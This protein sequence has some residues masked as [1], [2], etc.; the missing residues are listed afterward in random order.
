MPPCY[1]RLDRKELD[2][3]RWWG[4]T[5]KETQ[6]QAD[7]CFSPACVAWAR[8]GRA[9]LRSS[10]LPSTTM[11]V[12]DGPDSSHATQ[13]GPPTSRPSITVTEALGNYPFCLSTCGSFLCGS[14]GA[15]GRRRWSRCSDLCQWVIKPPLRE[16]GDPIHHGNNETKMN[17]SILT[18]LNNGRRLTSLPA[19]SSQR[20]SS[21][22][23]PTHTHTLT[24]PV[25]FL[26]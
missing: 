17:S 3:T 9:G 11:Q 18:P 12:T 13:I 19:D 7:R 23:P 14:G 20:L 6:L 26:L 16:A 24:P 4:N 22:T 10:Q 5:E 15:N 25:T 21:D 1:Y 2:H 8:W